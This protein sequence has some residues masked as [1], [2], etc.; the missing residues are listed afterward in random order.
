MI[1]FHIDSGTQYPNQN[2]Q[3]SKTIFCTHKQKLQI[4]QVYAWS[5]KYWRH[6]SLF[7]NIFGI[8]EPSGGQEVVLGKGSLRF[9]ARTSLSDCRFILPFL[10][11]L[12]IFVE[13][14]L[15]FTHPPFFPPWAPLCTFPSNP[16]CH[17]DSPG[18][19]P[20]YSFWPQR[21]LSEIWPVPLWQVLSDSCCFCRCFSSAE[22]KSLVG[23]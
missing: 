12:P 2:L 4:S 17:P 8:E 16:S 3:L 9:P 5:G 23:V 21:T 20:P 22:F 15:L 10:L 14:Y 6:L 19:S 7:H 1:S 13:C 11:F 18:I